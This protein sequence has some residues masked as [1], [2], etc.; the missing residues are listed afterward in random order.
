[1]VDRI[2]F[3]ILSKQVIVNKMMQRRRLKMIRQKALELALEG[4]KMQ[5]I[6]LLREDGMGIVVAKYL[7]EKLMAKAQL[8]ETQEALKA[9][10]KDH[11]EAEQQ[12]VK[13]H[14]V[15]GWAKF[16]CYCSLCEQARKTLKED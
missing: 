3:T 1:M 2:D 16:K 9:Y 12:L 13:N 10:I 15:T 7:L 4:R 5:A 11:D 6:R 8:K 14:E